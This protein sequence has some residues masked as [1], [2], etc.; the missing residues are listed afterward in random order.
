MTKTILVIQYTS[1]YLNISQTGKN[2]VIYWYILCHSV[3]ITMSNFTYN[4]QSLRI[5]KPSIN[6]V[7]AD[8]LSFALKSIKL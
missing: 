7:M 1:R 8:L 2:P 6:I 3:V 4:T 5:I